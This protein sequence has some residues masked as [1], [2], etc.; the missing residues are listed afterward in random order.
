MK[1]RS[2]S[3][4]S[5]AQRYAAAYGTRAAAAKVSRIGWIAIG[6]PGIGVLCR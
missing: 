4:C 3:R 6:T 1:R 2:S 5:A